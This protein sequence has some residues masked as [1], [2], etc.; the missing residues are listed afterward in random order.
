MA[1][2][3]VSS[4]IYTRV[5]VLH[6]KIN[7]FDQNALLNALLYY[8]SAVFPRLSDSFAARHA[9]RMHQLELAKELT[10]R[11]EVLKNNIA[12]AE[13]VLSMDEKASELDGDTTVAHVDPILDI[14]ELPK[15]KTD[16]EVTSSNT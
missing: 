6:L 5:L 15:R 7:L 4:H 1:L 14:A 11:L 10:T 3:C 8:Q 12:P 9:I 16:Y 13:P 2:S